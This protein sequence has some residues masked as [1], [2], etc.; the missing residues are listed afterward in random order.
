MV[1]VTPFSAL[2]GESLAGKWSL[3][4]TD[5]YDIDDGTLNSWSI[6]QRQFVF[7]GS[8]TA[9]PITIDGLTND[10]GYSCSV[11]S[12]LSSSGFDRKGETVEAGSVTPS[13]TQDDDSCDTFGTSGAYVQKIFVA[14]LGRPAAP[15]GLEYY[16]NYLDVDNEGGKLILFDD[17]YYSAEA[18]SLYDSMTLPRKLISFISLCSVGRTFR[19]IELLDRSNQ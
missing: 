10:R 15:A 9:S 17:L 18:S 16:A 11:T 13:A 7:P 1:P 14:Y 12:A 3:I 8:S 2:A 6:R 5:A 4:I 19:W